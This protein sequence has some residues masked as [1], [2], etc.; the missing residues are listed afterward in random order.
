MKKQIYHIDRQISVVN[1]SAGACYE[2]CK[3]RDKVIKECEEIL[4]LD[5]SN[6]LAWWEFKHV[7]DCH[8]DLKKCTVIIL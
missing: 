3:A 5:L 6:Q 4:R 8:L 2:P 7:L 1:L